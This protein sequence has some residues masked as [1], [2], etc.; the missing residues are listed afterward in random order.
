[1]IFQGES[2]P[3]IPPLDPHMFLFALSLSDVCLGR[4]LN[5]RVRLVPLNMF[6]PSSIFTGRSKA[7]LLL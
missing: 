1:M 5:I 3:L 2:G 4:H 6:K 7:V